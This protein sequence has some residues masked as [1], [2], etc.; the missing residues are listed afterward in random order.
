[1]TRAVVDYIHAYFDAVGLP[2]TIWEREA[3]KSN[4]CV[5]LR[6]ARA[7]TIL[8]LGHLDVVPAGNRGL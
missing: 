4:P 8:W 1:M 5:R 7:G 2:S 6:G 3:G